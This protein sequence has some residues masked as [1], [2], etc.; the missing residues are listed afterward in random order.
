MLPRKKRAMSGKEDKRTEKKGGIGGFQKVRH[1][2]KGRSW[3]RSRE[4]AVAG[5]AHGKSKEKE[6]K[7]IFRVEKKRQTE[8]KRR[9]SV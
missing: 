7:C 1:V 8:G 3:G 5:A 9:C 4:T 2:G 6:D